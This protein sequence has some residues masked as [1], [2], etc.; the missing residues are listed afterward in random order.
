MI[1]DK[2]EYIGCYPYGHAWSKAF[3]FLKSIEL[4]TE[5]KKYDIQGDDIF[6]IVTSYDTK[7]PQKFEAHREY[8]DIQC[9]IKGSEIIES[10]NI[11]ELVIETLYDTNNDVEFYTRSNVEKTVTRLTP[12]IFVVYFPHDAHI[13][14]VFVD[15]TPK[16][17]KKA[18][19]KIR[20]K[21]F[22]YNI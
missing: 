19:I 2:I 15:N 9:L 14:G 18:V 20:T 16:E 10:A 11:G 21:L 3:E 12:G 6:A 1:V 7:E 17:V 4:N 22:G 8:V 13:P 5:D